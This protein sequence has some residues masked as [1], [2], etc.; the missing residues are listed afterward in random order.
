M[1]NA[2]KELIDS[3]IVTKN[4]RIIAINDVQRGD[5]EIPTM[6]ILNIRDFL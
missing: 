4:D 5:K 1:D 6:S 2:I 3:K